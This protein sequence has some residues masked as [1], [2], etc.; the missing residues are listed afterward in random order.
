[1]FTLA[2]IN[3]HKINNN[4]PKPSNLI[5]RLF[6][7]VCFC[8]VFQQQVVSQSNLLVRSTTGAS[9]ASQAIT[10][11]GQTYIIQ[12][13]VGQPSVIGTIDRGNYIFRQGFIQP[14]V[15]AKIMDK[16]VPLNLQMRVY[17]NPFVER[18]TLD[19]NEMVKD[20]VDVEIFN[21]L[22]S[23]VFKG[24]YQPDQQIHVKLDKLSSGEY[25]FKAIANHKQF[26]TKI[27]K[28]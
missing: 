19:F 7:L 8:C 20:K 16:N 11:G 26:L 24:S 25:F 22:G 10:N 15:L 21:I 17:P 3:L 23:Q 4:S 13:S 27:I 1:M 14:D 18:I 2:E 9:G 6:I 28:R 12:Q 5:M